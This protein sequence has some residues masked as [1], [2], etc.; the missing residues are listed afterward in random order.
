[1]VVCVGCRLKRCKS[2]GLG[3]NMDDIRRGAENSSRLQR[4]K[5]MVLPAVIGIFFVHDEEMAG[6]GTT[7]RTDERIH[8]T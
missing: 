7:H 3:V 2:S 6:E 4:P 1:M 5:N 8:K